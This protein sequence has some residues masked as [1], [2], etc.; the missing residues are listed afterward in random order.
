MRSRITAVKVSGNSVS[1]PGNRIVL[2]GIEYHRGRPILYSLGSFLFGTETMIA[3]PAEYYEQLGL[4]PEVGPADL[5]DAR[6]HKSRH[7]MRSDPAFWESVIARLRLRDDGTIDVELVPVVLVSSESRPRRGYPA[8]A[9]P[10]STEAIMARL[11][12]LSRPLGSTVSLRD[13]GWQV[14]VLPARGGGPA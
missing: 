13:G 8:P 6:D 7:G 4:P 2:R 11:D 10:E 14:D 5:F 12:R 3:Q 9:S 1:V